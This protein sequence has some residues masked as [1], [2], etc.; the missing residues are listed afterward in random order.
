[1]RPHFIMIYNRNRSVENTA[2]ELLKRLPLAAVS[3]PSE[4]IFGAAGAGAVFGAIGAR[5]IFGAIGA[6][7]IDE[8][9]AIPGRELSAV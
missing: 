9:T 4:G 8:P 2:D 7:V 5:V 6:R 1:M 3:L